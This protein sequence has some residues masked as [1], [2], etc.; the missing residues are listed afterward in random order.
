MKFFTFCS[1]S[2]LAF[3]P[4]V[5][6]QLGKIGLDG[7][8]LPRFALEDATTLTKNIKVEFDK[9][10]GSIGAVDIS[11]KVT[12]QLQRLNTY[13]KNT[14]FPAVNPQRFYPG[15]PG[16]LRERTCAE[17]KA[18]FKAYENFFDAIISAR[19]AAGAAVCRNTVKVAEGV[20]ITALTKEA[21]TELDTTINNIRRLWDRSSNQYNSIDFFV[22]NCKA[23]NNPAGCRPPGDEC[24]PKPE[25]CPM[26]CPC[27]YGFVDGKNPNR[28]QCFTNQ[29]EVAKVAGVAGK[30][31]RASFGWENIKDCRECF[32]NDNPFPTCRNVL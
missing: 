7:K 14:L 20:A 22:Y 21:M 6:G 24:P 32:L 15:T 4:T 16:L 28:N 18:I 2:L 17:R 11:K 1:L 26:V 25:R 8:I 19:E 13:M 12:S 23:R 29:D 31:S 10:P 9:T 30:S 3:A 5:L 27:Y